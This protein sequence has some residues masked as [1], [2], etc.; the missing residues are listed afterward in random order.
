MSFHLWGGVKSSH[1]KGLQGFNNIKPC[2]YEQIK[3]LICEVIQ[4]FN[5]QNLK[6]TTKLKFTNFAKKLDCFVA[7]PFAP[8]N[9]MKRKAAFTL[10]EVLITLGI[11]GVVAALTLPTLIS[12]YQKRVYVTQL[13]KSVSVLSNGFKLMMAHDGVTELK[14][15]EAFS[16]IAD[17]GCD[18]DTINLPY[19]TPLKE[20]LQSTFAGITFSNSSEVSKFKTLNGT[21]LNSRGGYLIRFPDGSCIREYMFFKYSPFGDMGTMKGLMGF[22]LIDINGDKNPNTEGR[23]IFV[24]HVGNVG[25]VYPAGSMASSEALEGNPNSGYWRTATDAAYTCKIDGSSTG[26]GCAARVLEEDA[27][28]Y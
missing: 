19:C 18:N 16:K 28:N 9:D 12:N 11:I 1:S 22:I 27:M 25:G 26:E 21:L 2:H 6:R 13:K 23:D 10:A 14:D 4:P 8:R 20:A 7:K 24:L 15:T 3:G 17:S 5:Y